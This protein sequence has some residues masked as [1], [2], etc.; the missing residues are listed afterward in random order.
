MPRWSWFGKT[1]SWHNIPRLFW[2][3][4]IAVDGYVRPEGRTIHAAATGSLFC[5]PRP[6]ISSY[7]CRTKG[8]LIFIRYP[9]QSF[10]GVN[11]RYL[12]RINCVHRTFLLCSCSSVRYFTRSHTPPI[13]LFAFLFLWTIRH[14]HLRFP[15]VVTER[16]IGFTSLSSSHVEAHAR[17]AA[18]FQSVSLFRFCLICYSNFF[19]GMRGHRR[20]RRIARELRLH[21]TEAQTK[22]YAFPSSLLFLVGTLP[23]LPSFASLC[24]RKLGTVYGYAGGI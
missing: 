16:S 6:E 7:V 20:S 22:F 10:A 11:L 24:G 15:A 17:Y 2:I 21:E 4:L 14:A 23:I 1:G 13:P 8:P 5:C 19:L 18:I 9:Q 3:K 12:G